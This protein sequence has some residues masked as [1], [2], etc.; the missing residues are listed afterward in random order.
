MRARRRAWLVAAVAAGSVTVAGLLAVACK[1][2]RVQEVGLELGFGNAGGGLSCQRVP[3][4]PKTAIFL[5]GCTQWEP[6]SDAASGWPHTGERFAACLRQCDIAATQHSPLS[7]LRNACADDG[8]PLS[9]LFDAGDA[10]PISRYV[11]AD[12]CDV[13]RDKGEYFCTTVA[14]AV[15]VDL[16]GVPGYPGCRTTELRNA[17]AD[18][19]DC[20]SLAG[21]TVCREVTLEAGPV[22]AG[23]WREAGTLGAELSRVRDELRDLSL[24]DDAPDR[25]VIVH[26]VAR[27]GTCD[28]ADASLVGCA[29]S[30]PVVLTNGA[31][32]VH[33][34]LDTP[35]TCTAQ[36]VEACSRLG[37]GLALP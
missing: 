29:Y 33:V 16:V 22:Q 27:A 13:I 1:S 23:E 3:G 8:D 35:G 17:C 25:P 21:S 36:N 32:P 15:F 20:V 18:A 7:T 28:A 31:S 37:D 4:D 24:T 26:L 14:F 5:R 34:D 12:D 6:K 19:G 2:E 9:G 11:G 30:C 10:S